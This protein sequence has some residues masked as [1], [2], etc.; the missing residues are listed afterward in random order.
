[1]LV[2]QG[3]IN[4]LINTKKK[5]REVLSSILNTHL[6]G[7]TI[8]NFCYFKLMEA[9]INIHTSLSP[10]EHG[11]VIQISVYNRKDG[12]TVWQKTLYGQQVAV[13]PYF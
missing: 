2:Q 6:F 10:E 9:L 7:S 5:N 1:M 4:A 11:S 13:V 12:G 8:F 3:K